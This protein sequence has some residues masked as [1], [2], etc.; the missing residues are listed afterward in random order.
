ML[1]V[2]LHSP[3]VFVLG[4]SVVG[5]VGIPASL[6][7]ADQFHHRVIGAAVRQLQPDRIGLNTIELIVEGFR[8]LLMASGPAGQGAGTVY[9]LLV[10]VPDAVAAFFPADLPVAAEL[11]DTAF[12]RIHHPGK[13]VHAGYVIQH[14][15]HL[16]RR[17]FRSLDSR[18]LISGSASPSRE[19]FRPQLVALDLIH[20][21]IRFG[22]QIPK[23]P[24]FIHESMDISHGIPGPGNLSLFPE[25]RPVLHDRIQFLPE[26]RLGAV[27]EDHKELIPAVAVAMLLA[28]GVRQQLSGFAQDPIAL[29]MPVGIID[30]FKGVQI[31]Q[32]D[33]HFM[34]LIGV[35]IIPQRQAVP[36]SRQSIGPGG[37]LQ[38]LVFLAQLNG[39]SVIG[40]GQI[41]EFIGSLFLDRL[42]IFDPVHS[43]QDGIDSQPDRQ[44]DQQHRPQ[45][46]DDNNHPDIFHD[47]P[48]IVKSNR[49]G[50]AR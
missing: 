4:S 28:V 11:Q 9:A 38:P 23:V 42:I 46:L 40:P 17:I 2:I 6:L 25:D 13:I 49:L 47:V 16:F 20:F 15:A 14:H 39:Q 30:H 19:G 45:Q 21:L 33:C 37:L 27:R 24:L 34:P 8:L 41:T 48:D 31:Q 10:C 12:D 22:K 5:S 26:F 1:R 50:I 36:D 7:D 29:F 18:F 32:H 3:L 35:I 44:P 43:L